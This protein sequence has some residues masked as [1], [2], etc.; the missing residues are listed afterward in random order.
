MSFTGTVLKY[1]IS[2]EKLYTVHY[3]EFS[4][5]YRFSG[6][7]HNFWEIV[8][9]DKGIITVVAEDKQIQLKHGEMI[10]HKP[11]EWHNII[12]DGI[13]AANVAIVTFGSNSVAMDF[14]K[15]KIFTVGQEQKNLI[16]K[17]I[18]E[19]SNAFNTPLN[20]IFTN[21]L[22]AKSTP[23]FGSE[24]LIC[25]YLCE[26]L[27]TFIRQN[28]VNKQR[29]LISIN[30]ENATANMLVNYMIDNIGKKLTIKHL[31]DYASSNKMTVTRIFKNCF[32]MS[33]IEYFIHLKIELGKKYLRE[34][35]Y[36]VTQIAELL[37]Y[38]SV[39]YFSAQFKKS[40]GMSPTEY[41]L[42]AKAVSG[43][44]DLE[45]TIYNENSI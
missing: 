32:N 16:A 27:I 2:I 44:S 40:I 22:S 14:F 13:T 39:H 37:G 35:N 43:I 30:V 10:F 20:D 8:Y 4:K 24:Q 11:G 31:T 1:D 9:V 36:N 6:E 25:Q 12:A 45:R 5:D 7:K 17:I 38:S 29:T 34:N 21:S 19:Y 41:S 15:E 23:M 28:T 42:S 3:F 18:S 26:L 33:P